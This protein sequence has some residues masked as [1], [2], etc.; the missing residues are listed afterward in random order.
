MDTHKSEKTPERPADETNPQDKFVAGGQNP[1]SRTRSIGWLAIFGGVVSGLLAFALGELL[2]QRIPTELVPRDLMGTK[3][4]VPSPETLNVAATKNAALAFGALGLCLAGS[5]G[6]VGGLARR[7]GSSLLRGGLVGVVLGL[8]VGAGASL[9]LIPLSLEAQLDYPELDL[10][11]SLTTHAAIWGLL[12]A[13][14]GLALA[15]GFGEK[16]LIVPAFMAG[17]AGGILGA[18]VF[19]LIGGTFFGLAETGKPISATWLT[20]V[21]ARL[22]VSLGTAIGVVTVLPKE[23]E[24]RETARQTEPDTVPLSAP[25]P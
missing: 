7:Q 11:L 17:L 21:L 2:H 3:I 24:V 8:A 1:G 20:R 25:L 14:A 9:G 12:G 19:E 23:P 18:V 6:I 15:T 5:L 13:S 10:I 4:M 16:R 22:L